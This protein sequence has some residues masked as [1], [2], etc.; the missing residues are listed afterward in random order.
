MRTG[1]SWCDPERLRVRAYDVRLE[2]GGEL[3]GS[4]GTV[5]PVR[6][7]SGSEASPAEVGARR[8]GP[9]LAETYP[10]TTEGQYIVVDLGRRALDE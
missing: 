6:A 7:R 1:Q 5:H 10:V 9:Y 3:A 4:G 8:R 2:D